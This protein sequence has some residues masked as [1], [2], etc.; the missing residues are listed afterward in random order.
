MQ[1][2][3]PHKL[4]KGI[5]K[6]IKELINHFILIIGEGCL[7][8][9]LST[10]WRN[11]VQSNRLDVKMVLRLSPGGLKA[12]TKEHGLTEYWGHRVTTCSAP[13]HYPHIFAWVYRHETT[14]LKQE[15]RCHA[16]LCRSNAQVRYTL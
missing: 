15:L 1:K 16:V 3:R 7:E 4:A 12:T 14:R 10:L 13:S 9:P 2:I 11:Y 5:L 8:K 6:A